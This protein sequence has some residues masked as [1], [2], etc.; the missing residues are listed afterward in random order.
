VSSLSRLLDY[1]G[2]VVVADS[3][4]RSQGDGTHEVRCVCAIELGSGREHRV[5]VDGST[6]CPYPVDDRSLLVAHY[7][8][9]ELVTHDALGWPRP[10]NVLDTCV[11]FSAATAGKRRRDL[12]RGLVDALMYFNLP[13][14]DH[15][16]KD[17]MQAL[18]LADR[19]NNEYTSEERSALLEYCWS[20]VAGAARLLGVLE[21]YLCP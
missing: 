10:F 11:E 4:Y 3:E 12:G 9:A 15:H 8:S 7:A 16:E 20:D 13:H 19:R 1:F 5:W 14:L 17:E 21:G 18:A 6:V 2:E